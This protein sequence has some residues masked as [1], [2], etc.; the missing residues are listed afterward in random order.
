MSEASLLEDSI[1]LILSQSW[2]AG[3]KLALFLILLQI[4]PIPL[5]VFIEIFLLPKAP[6]KR[7]DPN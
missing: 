5:S 6:E 7:G 3:P 4:V 2:L 1:R